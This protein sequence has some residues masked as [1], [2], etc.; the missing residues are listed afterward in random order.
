MSKRY[1]FIEYEDKIGALTAYRKGHK[2]KLDDAL[3][4]VDFECEHLLPNWIPRRLGTFLTINFV[5]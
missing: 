4:L 2:M 5:N 3:L 1:A